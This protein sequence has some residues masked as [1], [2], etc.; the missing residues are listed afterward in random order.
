MGEKDRWREWKEARAEGVCL[1]CPCSCNR[2]FG[3]SSMEKTRV[4][5]AWM[6]KPEDACAPWDLC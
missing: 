2:G 4:R 5:T 1:D 6:Y 3:C